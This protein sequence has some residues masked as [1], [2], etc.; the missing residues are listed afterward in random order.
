M[1]VY[2]LQA[3]KY[4][5]DI[6]GDLN[7]HT[8]GWIEWNVLLDINGGPTCIGPTA[9]TWCV[10]DIGF[11]DAPILFDVKNQKLVYRDTYFIM[12]HF[13]RYIPRGSFIVPV[14]I[15]GQTPLNITAALT[16][17]NEYVVVVLNTQDTKSEMYQVNVGQQWV[18]VPQIDAHA[19]HT[20]IIPKN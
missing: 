11:C 14:Q 1:F 20:V 2:I 9:D 10:P 3:Q 16:P 13:S 18:V 12:A 5:V 6:I 17:A 7:Q 19:I 4:A 8:V 15:D